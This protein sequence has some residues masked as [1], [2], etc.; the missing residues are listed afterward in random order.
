MKA[1]NI[2][3]DTLIK[4]MRFIQILDSYPTLKIKISYNRLPEG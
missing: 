4:A 2:Y 3:I 1:N